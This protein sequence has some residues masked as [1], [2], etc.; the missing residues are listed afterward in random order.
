MDS[1]RQDL[2]DPRTPA[3]GTSGRWQRAA[4]AGRR[5][6]STITHAAL[7]GAASAAGG[8]VVTTV[9]WWLNHR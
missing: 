8:A 4:R 3:N 1:N 7:R 6:A 2:P 9:I 5:A